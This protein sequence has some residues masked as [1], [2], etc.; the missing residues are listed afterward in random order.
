L[1]VLLLASCSVTKYV[2]DGMYLLDDVKVTMTEKHSDIN[3]SKL[4]NYV[5]QKGNSR[6]FSAFKL[7]LAA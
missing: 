7:P 1:A 3:T 4:K 2:P 5:R 6:W